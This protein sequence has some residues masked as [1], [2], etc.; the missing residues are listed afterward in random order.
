MK[1]GNIVFQITDIGEE[2]K[3]ELNDIEAAAKAFSSLALAA[4]DAHEAHFLS[5][6]MQ[7]AEIILARDTSGE[8]EETLISN[9]HKDRAFIRMLENSKHIKA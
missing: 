1:E 4:W 2:F 7:T 8:L 9:A 5:V 6:I 3:Y